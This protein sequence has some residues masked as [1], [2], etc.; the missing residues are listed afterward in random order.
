MTGFSGEAKNRQSRPLPVP[1]CYRRM[2]E[3]GFGFVFL[4][5]LVRADRPSAPGIAIDRVQMAS[6]QMLLSCLTHVERYAWLT[7]LSRYSHGDRSRSYGH[8]VRH[9]SIDLV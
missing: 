1:V 9:Y 6:D 4:A 2:R 5:S 7:A 8:T 3:F